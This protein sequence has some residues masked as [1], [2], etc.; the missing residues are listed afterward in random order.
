MDKG[1]TMVVNDIQGNKIECRIICSFQN[2]QNKKNYIIYNPVAEENNENVTLYSAILK[3]GENGPTLSMLET[4]EDRRIVD[5]VISKLENEV[6]N[7][8][9]E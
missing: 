4:E 9:G 2:E 3:N 1:E 5:E 7:S 6:A 8:S